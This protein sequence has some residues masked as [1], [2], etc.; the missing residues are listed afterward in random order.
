MPA[1]NS[2]KDSV[3][4]VGIGHT[5]FARSLSRHPMDLIGEAMQRISE[6]KSVSSLF[7]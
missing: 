5:E 1:S 2:L 4:I 3:A 6:E 7:D